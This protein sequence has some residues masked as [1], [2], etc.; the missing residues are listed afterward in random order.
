MWHI[1]I[2]PL[3]FL[4]QALTQQDSPRQL[5]HGFA[6]GALV[7]LVP[8]DNLIAAVLMTVLCAARINLGAG[9][10]AAFA[11]S[12]IGL[13]A[14]PLL[15]RSGLFLLEWAPLAPFWTGLYNLPVVPWTRFNNTVVLGGLAVGLAAY[16]PLFRLMEP[17]FARY[18]PRVE[19][20]LRRYR[21]VRVLLGAEWAGRLEGA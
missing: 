7:G 17:L 19:Q 6:L 21:V 4:A 13:L 12:W 3:G 11:F 16:Y 20:R 14:D 15:H 9:L 8:K 1:V 18:K 10:L 2:R 5:A